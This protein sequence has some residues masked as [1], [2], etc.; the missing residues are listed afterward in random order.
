MKNMKNLNHIIICLF[1]SLG[2]FALPVMAQQNGRTKEYTSG[3]VLDEKGIPLSEVNISIV[4]DFKQ[5]STDYQGKF[6]IDVPVGK[7]LYFSKLGYVGQKKEINERGTNITVTL[8]EDRADFAEQ[9]GYVTRPHSEVTIA[10]SVI[11]ADELSR[12]SYMSAESA[13][14]SKA[15]GLTVLRG[16]GNEPGIELNNLYIRGIGTENAMRSPYVLVDDIERSIGGLDVHEIES[17]TILKDGAANAQYGQRGANGTILVTTKR[18]F[19]GKPEIQFISQVGTQQPT[20]RPK[21]LGAREY[22]SF[23]NKALLNDGLSIPSGPKYDP[24]TYTGMQNQL[25][26]PDVNWYDEFIRENAL[27]QQYKVTFR[28]GTDVIRYFM[29]LG[30]MDQNGLYKYTNLNDGYS[31]NL[32]Y[33]RFNVRA[34]LDANVTKSLVVSLDLAARVENKNQPNTTTNSVFSALSSIV[35][36][37]MP[38]QYPEERLAGTSQYQEN[39]L[40][41]ISR[42]GYS[43][44][45][46]ITLQV[47]AKAVQDLSLLTEGL[48]AELVF[49]YDGKS[50]YGLMKTEQYATNEW[51]ADGT[52]T[53]YGE[54]VPLALN[55]SATNKD[56]YYLMS[57]FGG[58]NYNRTFFKHGVGGNIRYYQAQTFVRADNPPYGKQG[59]NGGLNYNYDKRYF[60]DFSF[61]YDGSDEYAPGNRFGFFPAVS[62]AWLISNE[63]FLKYNPTLTFLKLRASYG[64]AGNCK[65]SGLDRYA[66]QSHWS[67]YD[68]SWGGYIFGSGFPWSDGAWEGRSPNPGLTWETTK[69]FNV[70]LDFSLFNNLSVSV[71]GFIHKRDNIIMALENTV[72]SVVGNPSSY[73]NIGKVTNK[74]F[75][76]SVTYSN[77]VNKLNYYVQANASF[78]RNEITQTDEV[79]NLAANLKRT[80]HSVTQPFGLLAVGYYKDQ[81]DIDHSPINALYKVR[82]GDIKYEDINKDGI[83]NEQDEMAIGTPE[84]PEWTLG[85]SAGVEYNGFD[86]SFLLSGY[87]GRSVFMENANAWLLQNNG[88]VTAL[89]YGA[90]EAGVREDNATYPRLTTESNRNNYRN[91]TYWLKNG[92]FL[93]LSNVELGYSFPKKWIGKINLKELRLYVNGQNLFTV[94][95]LGDFNVDPEVVNAGITDYPMVRTFNVGLSV[96]F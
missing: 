17:V 95:R 9:L 13:L 65:T 75:E 33:N 25:L 87:A 46:A 88:N 10:N 32:N 61:A 67:G 18:G 73:A 66:Y 31:T 54:D 49:G 93:R 82:P 5:V 11:K 85:L 70:G 80:G 16:N 37:A 36:N 30:Y 27:Q 8:K 43:Q 89:A 71:D 76:A 96:K 77:K 63:K 45:R 39:P 24:D 50:S 35:P 72:P 91:S 60:V 2:A 74:G 26:Y 69:N 55:M 83:I 53:Q 57:F 90:W 44:N 58:L 42:T 48:N 84:M 40:G 14:A 34:N 64:E 3:V 79:A 56:Y 19:V 68:A 1:V 12:S 28:G 52:Y 6:Q 59:I 21:Y 94:D 29:L 20:H 51:Q 86:L 15:T 62:A 47:K 41:M 23:Y 22:V 38:V 7:S 92:N 81:N 78:A 4:D